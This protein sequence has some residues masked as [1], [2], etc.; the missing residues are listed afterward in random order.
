MKLEAELALLEDDHRVGRMIGKVEELVEV[1]LGD[2]G[3][4]QITYIYIY[5]HTHDYIYIY[6]CITSRA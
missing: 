6:I 2:G 4:V 5:I 3:P 1:A